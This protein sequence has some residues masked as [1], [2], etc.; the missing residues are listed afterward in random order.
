MFPY[1]IEI[2]DF[3]GYIF[4]EHI[5][6]SNKLLVTPMEYELCS[7]GLFYDKT[8]EEYLAFQKFKKFYFK[9]YYNKLDKNKEFDFFYSSI[10]FDSIK[11]Y[12][13]IFETIKKI[14]STD[15]SNLFNIGLIALGLMSFKNKELHLP[16]NFHVTTNSNLFIDISLALNNLKHNRDALLN[17]L[18]NNQQTD[19]RFGNGFLSVLSNVAYIISTKNDDLKNQKTAIDN[20]LISFDYFRKQNDE[21]EMDFPNYKY[22]LEDVSSVIYGKLLGKG[23]MVKYEN[24]NFVQKYFLEVLSMKYKTHTYTMLYAGILPIGIDEKSIYDIY[25]IYSCYD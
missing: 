23:N 16:S 7:K 11:V 2:L 3:F 19:L 12:N 22:L 6:D 24:M 21:Q 20:I 8:D 15:N 25:D 4:L 14:D 18:C 13:Y 10:L 17:L 1:K 5:R 9:H